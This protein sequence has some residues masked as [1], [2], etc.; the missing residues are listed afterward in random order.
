MLS[1]RSLPVLVALSLSLT[2]CE[3]ARLGTSAGDKG[4]RS[5][6]NPVTFRKTPTHPPITLVENGQP[7]AAIYVATGS[8]SGPLAEAVRELQECVE[9]ATGA[10]LAVSKQIPDGPAIVI[11]DCGEAAAQGLVGGKMPV[12]GF[13]IRTQG[14][15]VFIVGNDEPIKDAPRAAS[16]GT[17]WGI[18]EFLERFVGVRW[19]YPTNRGGRSIVKTDT[20]TVPPVWLADAPSFRKREIWPPCGNPWNG[21]GQALG[22]LH[23]RLRGNDSWPNSLVVHSPNWSNVKE[24]TEGRPEV[25]QQ[26]SDGTR[27]F[28]MLCY[29][30]PKTLQTYL[31]NT[32][33]HFDEKKSARLGICGNAITVSPNDAA[34]AC[35]CE[36][37]RKLWDN[38]GGQYGTAS[39]VL[40]DFVNRLAIE[41]KK[42]WRDKTVIFLPYLNYTAAPDGYRFPGNVEVQLCGMPGIA[43]YKEPGICASEQANIDKWLKIT[44]R[45]IQNWHYSCWPEDKTKSPYHYFH[46]LKRFYQENRRKLVGSFINGVGDHWPRQHIDLYCWMKVL[47]NP[48]FDVDAAVDEYCRRM[49]GPAA[50]TMRE[51]IAL[52]T[53]GWE[54]SR[55]PGGRLSPKGIYEVSYPKDKVQ[56]MQELLKTAREQAAGDPAALAHL[57]YYE[58]PFAEFLTEYKAVIEGEGAHSLTAQKVGENPVIDGKLDD[59][60]W[61]KA[62]AAGFFKPVDNKE[63]EPKYPTRLMAVWTL[64]GVTFGFHNTEPN[65]AALV[66]AINSRDD[67]MAW[68]DDNVEIFIDVTGKKEG[69]YYQLIINPNCAIADFKLEDATWDA[70]GAKTKVHIDKDFWSLEVYLPYSAFPEAVKPGTGVEWFGQFTRHRISDSRQAKDSPREYTRMNYKFGG[71]SRNLADFAPIRFVE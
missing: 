43:Q 7:K 22:P 58:T 11:G 27:D 3:I 50:N 54:K 20:L 64:D 1:S 39:R 23:T 33:L 44:G 66:R 18:F 70:P 32:A 65:P 68:W 71:P 28:S 63:A 4:Q 59:P 29:G 56:R 17:A 30:H 52:Q 38:E 16:N 45:R 51:L 48:D 69:E 47:W 8:K 61:Q 49:Y 40:A 31:E 35:Y 57:D 25:F 2:G 14:S 21:S 34:I 26:R 6:L 9:L 24:Y 53:D 62:P 41:V 13:A 46:V 67:S 15:R 19:Y 60:V 5:D 37:C 42:R 36:H 12:E 10:K 55:W